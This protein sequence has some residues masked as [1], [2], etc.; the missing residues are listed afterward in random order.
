[1]QLIKNEQRSIIRPLPVEHGLP[2]DVI[3][4][5]EITACGPGKDMLGQRGF[6][7]LAGTADKNHLLDKILSDV[8]FDISHTA[9][10]HCIL[11]QSR[12]F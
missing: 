5:V 11:K 7:D 8:R 12:L 10:L 6:S 2:V 9:I 1:M 3:I 4:P